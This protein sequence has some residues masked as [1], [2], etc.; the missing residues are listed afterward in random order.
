MPA[1]SVIVPVY[2]TAAYLEKCIESLLAQTL[3]D[4]ELIFVDDGSTDKSPEILESFRK[5]APERI[6]VITQSNG[7]QGKAR[8]VGLAAAVGAYIGFVDSDDTVDRRMYAAMYGKAVSEDLDLVECRFRYLT[9]DGREKTPYGQ[10]ALGEGR[11]LFRHPLVSPWNKLIRRDL[12]VQNDIRFPEG[13]IYED[14]SFYLKLLPYVRRSGSLIGTY[15]SHLDRGD[16][17]MNDSKSQKVGHIFPVLEDALDYY[18]ARGLGE[19]YAKELEYFCSRIL[20]CSSM[21]RITRIRQWKL[22]ER[23]LRE[24]FRFLETHFPGYR[25]N[26]LLREDRRALYLCHSSVML[27]RVLRPVLRGG[28]V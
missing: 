2:N 14:T 10:P 20:L 18:N 23:Y 7:G 6:R 8:N 4:L 27:C 17:T 13:Y 5:R 25:D 1:V 9:E 16:S 19:S 11:A 21:R 3:A 12:L 28:G 22:R 15:V 26:G 24:T